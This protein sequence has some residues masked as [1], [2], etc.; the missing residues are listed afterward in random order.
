LYSRHE[1]RTP[2]ATRFWAE[3]TGAEAKMDA[4]ILEGY[5]E[6]I[7]EIMNA[8]PPELRLAGL[9]PEQLVLSLPDD[10]LRVLSPEFLARLPPDCV[11]RA[12]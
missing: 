7:K 2:R 10:L 5:E 6:Q 11:F 3:L 1:V 8:M 9:A 4:R 12:S